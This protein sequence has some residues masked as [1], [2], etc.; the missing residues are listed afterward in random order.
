MLDPAVTFLNHGSFGACPRPVFEAYQRYQLELERQPVEFLGRRFHE[1]LQPARTALAELVGA[2]ADALLLVANATE[3]IN[4]V[5]RSLPLRPGDEILTTDHE[6]GAVDLTWEF[7]AQ[8]TGAVI[9]RQAIPLPLTD[10]A[11]VVKAVWAGV[12][13][14]TRVISMSHLTS[15]T[16]MIFPIEEICRRARAAGIWT[17]IDGAHAPGHIPLNLAGLEVDFY[18]GNCHKWLCAAKGAGFLYVNRALQG[19]IEPLVVSWGWGQGQAWVERLQWTGTRDIA[20]FLSVADAIQF[21]R[22]HGWDEV[23]ARCRAL[24]LAARR[25]IN[26]LTGAPDLAPESMIGQMAA[27]SLPVEDVFGLKARLYDRHRIELPAVKWGEW[28]LLR[29]S[30]QGYNTPDE[31]ERLV[32]ALSDVGI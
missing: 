32:M 11:E 12:T 21:Q 26:A 8:K 2:P 5:A 30:I 23:R 3:G 7:I 4:Q 22:D 20:A 14:R 27:V 6:Y 24:A 31:V 16:A 9:R 10:P 19:L 18:A 15:P 28:S 13:E 25:R 17:V 29:V 1:L